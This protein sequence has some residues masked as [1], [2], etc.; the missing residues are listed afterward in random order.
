[1]F[2]FSEQEGR[3]SKLEHER[4]DDVSAATTAEIIKACNWGWAT[5]GASLGCWE[6]NWYTNSTTYTTANS[7]SNA[8]LHQVS[9]IISPRRAEV[10]GMANEPFASSA[11]VYIVEVQVHGYNFDLS[12]DFY[13]FNKDTRRVEV[14]G[15]SVVL[16]RESSEGWGWSSAFVVLE[17]SQYLGTSSHVAILSA[18]N[19]GSGSAHIRSIGMNEIRHVNLAHERQAD[20]VAQGSPW[21]DLAGEG[22]VV[23]EVDPDGADQLLMVDRAEGAYM[24]R[25]E[26]RKDFHALDFHGAACYETPPEVSFGQGVDG[27]WLTSLVYQDNDT[28]AFMPWSKANEFGSRVFY[29]YW[30]GSLVGPRVVT[31]VDSADGSTHSYNVTAAR[32]AALTW[33]DYTWGWSFAR[34]RFEIYFNGSLVTSVDT[35]PNAVD[36]MEDTPGVLIWGAYYQP[37]S[38]NW[39]GNMAWPSVIIGD[40]SLRDL[41]RYF[42]WRRSF[43]GLY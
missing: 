36:Y 39:Q 2:E 1:M 35:S 7:Y 40:L 14:L 34:Q 17:E 8:D 43:H 28:N 11:K 25:D 19:T 22:E 18:R 5:A 41:Q 4:G 26:I 30:S 24:R 42:W 38:Y 10:R 9:P 27:F 21:V 12:V 13:R 33:V 16:R 15:G 3:P 20:L 31:M 29:D 23:D 32:P 37:T 6:V